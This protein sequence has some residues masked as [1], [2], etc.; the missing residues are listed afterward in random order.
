MPI[1]ACATIFGLFSVP[2]STLQ[3]GAREGGKEGREGDGEET[4]D[5][6]LLPREDMASNKIGKLV[7]VFFPDMY[8]Y[9]TEL[10]NLKQQQHRSKSNSSS[11]S[12]TRL[13]GCAYPGLC[14]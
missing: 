4:G 13:C 7:F 3:E 14:P 8:A 1:P 12:F 5:F 11:N 9:C 2:P 6:Q 10:R